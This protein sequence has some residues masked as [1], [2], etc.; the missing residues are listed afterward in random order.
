MNPFALVA[1]AFIVIGGLSLGY[2]FS[3][4]CHLNGRGESAGFAGIALAFI[5]AVVVLVGII[6]LAVLGLISAFSG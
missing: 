6:I 2:L 3:P 1:L 5:S 4:W